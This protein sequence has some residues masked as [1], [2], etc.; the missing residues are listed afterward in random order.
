MKILSYS[1]SVAAYA[2]VFGEGG[3]RTYYDLTQDIVSCSVTRNV[4]TNSTFTITLAN[5]KHKYNGLFS[6]MDAVTIFADKNGERTQLITGYMTNVTK[7]TLY[8]EN[9]GFGA[10]PF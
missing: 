1:P 3:S 10:V 6:P 5:R 9:F 8:E 4:D 7:F 2:C